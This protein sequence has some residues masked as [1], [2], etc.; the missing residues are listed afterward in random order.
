LIAQVDNHENKRDGRYSRDDNQSD[1][2]CLILL[3]HLR[4]SV[5]V[6]TSFKFVS[7]NDHLR[8]RDTCYLL[9]AYLVFRP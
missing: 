5:V 2:L 6:C 9:L 3:K 7:R 8:Q 1:R 4:I